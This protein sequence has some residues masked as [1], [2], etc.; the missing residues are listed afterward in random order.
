MKNESLWNSTLKILGKDLFRQMETEDVKRK[1]NM[2]IVDTIMKEKLKSLGVM[3]RKLHMLFPPRFDIEISKAELYY[4][5]QK[6]IV[7]Y[8]KTHGF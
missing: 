7:R 5:L 1:V 4:L 8:K 3:S 6:V 2:S